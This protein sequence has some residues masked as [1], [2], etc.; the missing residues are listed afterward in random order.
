[1]LLYFFK[2]T[3]PS[4]LIAILSILLVLWGHQFIEPHLLLNED[5]NTSPM[6]LYGLLLSFTQDSSSLKSILT[7]A[8]FVILLGIIILFN[9]KDFF[10]NQR[11]FLP[12]LFYILL[13]AV[14]V[15]NQT[16]NPVLPATIFL[17]LALIRI[18]DSYKKQGVSYCYFDAGILISIGSL[19]YANL[20]W[21]GILLFVGII[22]LRTINAKEI[23]TALIGLCAPFV[24]I[25]GYFYVFGEDISLFF[26][27]FYV[28]L[29]SQTSNTIISIGLIPSLLIS[30]IIIVSIIS[31][32]DLLKK[33]NTKKNRSRNTFFLFLWIIGISLILIA[34][35]TVRMEILWVL[36][37]PFCFFLGH[38][39]VFAKE[40]IYNRVL[41]TIMLLS[42]F[43]IQILEWLTNH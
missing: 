33:I 31:V 26:H 34:T 43:A 11:S 4:C 32:F 15:T 19:F 18:L 13:N 14:I 27:N 7:I 23:L 22:I 16:F 29:F 2:K 35:R 28:N 20:I 6:P 30:F 8:T 5:Y 17:L 24:I 36:T 39:F 21:Y 38:Y 10:I 25:V 42:V 12:A 41:F 40:N 37:L 9:S 1:M 3:L